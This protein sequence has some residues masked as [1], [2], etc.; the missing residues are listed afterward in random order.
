MLLG[1]REVR[2]DLKFVKDAGRTRSPWRSQAGLEVRGGVRPDLKYVEESGRTYSSWRSQAGQAV[3]GLNA[4]VMC[5]RAR[6]ENY[7]HA[8]NFIHNSLDGVLGLVALIVCMFSISSIRVWMEYYGN[9]SGYDCPDDQHVSNLISLS[10]QQL[11][12]RSEL[13]SRQTLAGSR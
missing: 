9:A 13:G 4:K 12:Y 6:D 11:M 5:Q 3:P 1:Q 8:F 7:V 2:P 10:L